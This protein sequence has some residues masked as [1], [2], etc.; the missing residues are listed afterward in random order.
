LSGQVPKGRMLVG[1]AFSIEDVEVVLENLTFQTDLRHRFDGAIWCGV[2]GG[3][4][5]RG[6]R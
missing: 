3:V 1:F 4:Q 5:V 2:V 6:W